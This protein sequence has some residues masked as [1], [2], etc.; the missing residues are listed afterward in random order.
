MQGDKKGNIFIAEFKGCRVRMVSSNIITTIVGS[1]LCRYAT[2]DV[3]PQMSALVSS[4]RSLLVVNKAA[5]YF[6][7]GGRLTLATS[8][9]GE[10]ESEEQL[11]VCS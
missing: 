4:V 7:E 9:E 6:S 3:Q 2:F 5:L 11:K 1:D 8:L 10:E